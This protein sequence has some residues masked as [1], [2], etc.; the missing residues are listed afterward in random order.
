MVRTGL[1]RD[2]SAPS[3]RR[4]P[5]PMSRASTA[6]WVRSEVDTY[7]RRTGGRTCRARTRHTPT[8]RKR[9]DVGD[10]SHFTRVFGATG[11]N[12]AIHQVR[13][14]IRDRVRGPWCAAPWPPG[15]PAQPVGAHQAADRA[16]RG[17]RG[18]AGAARGT[19]CA[20][21][22]PRS[23]PCGSGGWCPKLAAS[24]TTRAHGGPCLG[25]VVGARGDRRATTYQRLHDRL[26]PRAPPG[27]QSMKLHAQPMWQSVSTLEQ[28]T[29][30]PAAGSCSP[31]A[32]SRTS[33]SRSLIR[34]ASWRVV[35]RPARPR[36]RPRPG[37]PSCATPRDA[38]RAAARSSE[39]A[40]RAVSG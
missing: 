33:R 9:A 36:R 18:P 38:P 12:W 26:D 10:V 40:P 2:R 31:G 35:T 27:E 39:I 7:Q 4:S 11:W 13:G 1:L 24:D 8:R 29:R 14:P 15:N 23:C 16:P 22:R 34:S 25:R 19:P 3:R 21:R 5:S 32:A 17:G 30:L 28:S 6:S 37:A 20:P